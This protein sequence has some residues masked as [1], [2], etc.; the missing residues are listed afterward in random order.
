MEV[1]C[2]MYLDK[3]MRDKSITNVMLA[4]HFGTTSATISRWRHNINQPDINILPRLCTFLN[5][6]LDDL[7]GKPSIAIEVAEKTS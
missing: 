7:L 6:S 2:N 3:L 4:E 5:C 1:I